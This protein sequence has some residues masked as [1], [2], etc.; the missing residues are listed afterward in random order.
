MWSQSLD[1]RKRWRSISYILLEWIIQSLS[2]VAVNH[3]PKGGLPQCA[4]EHSDPRGAGYLSTPTDQSRPANGLT[5]S[6]STF[7]SCAR[8]LCEVVCVCVCVERASPCPWIMVALEVPQS[9][10]LVPLTPPNQNA[11]LLF[12]SLPCSCNYITCTMSF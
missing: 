1:Q 11:P 2:H 5:P 10:W 7:H 4:Q 6:P 8:M 12:S 9:F 3:T